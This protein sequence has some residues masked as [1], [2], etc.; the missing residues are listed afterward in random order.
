MLMTTTRRKKGKKAFGLLVRRVIAKGSALARARV[1]HLTR[2]R[3]ERFPRSSAP[4]QNSHDDMNARRVQT[5][6]SLRAP[7]GG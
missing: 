4:K 7:S 5:R 2:C 3:P 1:K 6:A